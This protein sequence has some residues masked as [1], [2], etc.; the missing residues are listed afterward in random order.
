YITRWRMQIAHR[1]ITEST[2]TI[3][4]I[5]Q[6]CAYQSEEAFSKAFR[7][8]FGVSPKAV[9]R[10]ESVNEIAS[11]VSVNT[12]S[13]VSS[14]ILYSPQEVNQLRNS[15]SVVIID[16]RDH[17]DYVQGHIPG[18]V[19]LPQLFTTLSMTTPEGL[20]EMEKTFTP[21]F[22][23]AGVSRDKT[24]IF[25]EDDLDSRFGGSCRGYFQ[26]TLLG[27]SN[28]GVLDGGLKQWKA[29]AYPLDT[30]IPSPVPS[31]FKPSLQRAYL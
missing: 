13:L 26:L 24:V 17:K 7:K 4:D 27:H 19:N 20:S 12:G 18:A 23:K 11:M 3:G 10:R 21:L 16:I 29:E 25:Y 22:S 5:A 8:E 28:T 2:E 31:V 30:D 15:Q 1:M 6:S 9:R 14:K